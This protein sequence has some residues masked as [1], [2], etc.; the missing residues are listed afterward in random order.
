MDYNPKVVVLRVRKDVPGI[1]R[2]LSR[3]YGANEVTC[4]FRPKYQVPDNAAIINYGRSQYP[5]WYM[6]AR[7]RGVTF[8]NK[9]DAVARSVDKIQTLTILTNAG[10]PCLEFTTKWEEAEQWYKNGHGIIARKTVTGKQGKG[11]TYLPPNIPHTGIQDFP[12][13]TKHYAKDVEFRVHVV[14]GKVVDY[15]QKKRMG[16]EKLS[17]IGLA[18]PD[19]LLRN[20]KRGWVFARN[21]IIHS[22]TV[23][24]MAIRATEALGLDYAGID[25]LA[26]VDE[27]GGIYDAVVCESNSAPGMNSPTT[28]KAYTKAFDLLINKGNEYVKST[29]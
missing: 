18:E 17:K 3:Y 2:K 6:E 25:I 21:N 22:E 12:L 15:V 7:E 27:E 14:D 20:H 19:M 11:I 16:R 24:G 26:K 4:N 5:I 1:G 23:K 13:Y 28:F 9:P 10:I 8:I 29:G